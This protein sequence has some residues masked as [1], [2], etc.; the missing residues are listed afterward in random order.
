MAY[1]NYVREHMRFIKIASDLGLSGNERSLWYALMAI[2]NERASGS[3]WPEDKMSINNKALLALVPF[4]ANKLPEI[5]NKLKQAGLIDFEPG[6]R[7]KMAAK[8]RILYFY[9]E[10]SAGNS[11]NVES[12]HRNGDKNGNKDGYKNGN[13]Y[14]YKN[15]NKDGYFNV[16]LNVTPNS[17]MCEDDVDADADMQ[18]YRAMRNCVS[19][20]FRDEVGR[21]AQP[22]ELRLISMTAINLGMNPDLAVQAIGKAAA[23]GAK[24]PASY[25]SEIMG[26]WDYHGIHTVYDL[27]LSESAM[28]G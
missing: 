14:G 22:A 2:A 17:N 15:G 11:H 19:R 24:S 9:P 3:D 4:T 1:V 21:D 7:N 5:R 20:A 10:L 27:V 25:A 12:Y 23:R 8:Y 18:A 13:K 28:K 6:K 16:N 26:S